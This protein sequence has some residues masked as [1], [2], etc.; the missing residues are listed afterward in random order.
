MQHFF[1]TAIT[2][3]RLLALAVIGSLVS[4]G[5]VLAMD[6]TV[7]TIK[8][9]I[10]QG[11]SNEQISRM[12]AV[13]AEE[14]PAAPAETTTPAAQSGMGKLVAPVGDAGT[15][16]ETPAP[17]AEKPGGVVK[18]GPGEQEET[19][20][21]VAGTAKDY[22]TGFWQVVSIDDEAGA[23]SVI[24]NKIKRTVEIWEIGLAGSEMTIAAS[25]RKEP[26]KQTRLEVVDGSYG[27]G[28]F[29][30]TI[31]RGTSETEYYFE[32]ETADRMTGE[33]HTIDH[34]LEQEGFGDLAKSIGME[35][36]IESGAMVTAERLEL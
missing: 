28:E 5:P 19:G 6:C 35:S 21:F 7:D 15:A 13:A 27:D 26:R 2:R 29:E 25:T 17:V 33:S 1:A 11:F 30:V 23:A 10:D 22:L 12:C 16:A 18:L 3:P 14:V 24:S 32:I 8:M 4:V 34:Y 36:T 31:K 20:P 9:L